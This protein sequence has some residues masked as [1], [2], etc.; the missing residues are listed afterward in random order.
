LADLVTLEH[1]VA[2]RALRAALS[3]PDEAT[4][5]AAKRGVERLAG[6]DQPRPQPPR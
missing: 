6:L 3:S 1:V 4:R 5:L 2:Q